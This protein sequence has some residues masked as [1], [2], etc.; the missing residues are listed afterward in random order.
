MTGEI[1]VP[2]HLGIISSNPEAAVARYERP[3][4]IFTPLTLPIALCTPAR[5][6]SQSGWK[7]LCYFSQ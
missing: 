4:F 2:H 7:P 6:L 3:G 1:N 5:S